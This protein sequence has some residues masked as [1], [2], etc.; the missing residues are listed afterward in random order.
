MNKEQLEI[1]CELAFETHNPVKLEK[2]IEETVPENKH[3]LK[4]LFSTV[5]DLYQQISCSIQKIKS[6]QNDIEEE[7]GYIQQK[8]QEVNEALKQAD[9][10]G[11][12]KETMK[13]TFRELIANT[14]YY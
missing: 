12:S 1:L 9:S 6:A 7:E 5:G 4:E 11:I 8:Q 10:L 3:D 2:Y 14:D 13:D